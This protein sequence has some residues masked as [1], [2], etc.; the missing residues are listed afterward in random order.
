MERFEHRPTEFAG[1][2]DGRL[3]YIGVGK[4]EDFDKIAVPEIDHGEN[5]RGHVLTKTVAENGVQVVFQYWI[6]SRTN[7]AL[8]ADSRKIREGLSADTLLDDI[9]LKN[10]LAR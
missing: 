9:D 4:R 5:D 6:L 7:E 10:L 8:I 2:V 1:I 3:I